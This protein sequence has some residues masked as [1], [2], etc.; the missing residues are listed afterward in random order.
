VQGELRVVAG[1]W[2]FVGQISVEWQLVAVL[3]WWVMVWWLNYAA[4]RCRENHISGSI[5][6][7]G[8]GVHGNA[9]TALRRNYHRIASLGAFVSGKQNKGLF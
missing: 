1:A 2:Q 6:T 3:T 9:G 7:S 4:L 8:G 5:L